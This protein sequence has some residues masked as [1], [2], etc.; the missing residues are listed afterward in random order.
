M[1]SIRHI[2]HS[3]R[4]IPAEY[5][6]QFT[7]SDQE[8]GHELLMMTDSYTEELFAQGNELGSIFP[9]SRLLVDPERFA[10]DH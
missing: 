9:I 10:D 3:S 5:R 6:D 4:S 1:N 2:P 8:L 7:Q